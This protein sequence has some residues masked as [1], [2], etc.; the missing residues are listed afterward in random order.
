M[1]KH[2]IKK[3]GRKEQ[4]IKEKIIV[5]VVKTGAPIEVARKIADDIE[6]QSEQSIKTIWIMNHVIKKLE[7]HNPELPKIWYN[8]DKN[9][10]RLRKY[11]F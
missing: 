5:S 4:F 9:I 11:S 2:V 1:P 7:L 6:K 8:Y 3:D 10:K